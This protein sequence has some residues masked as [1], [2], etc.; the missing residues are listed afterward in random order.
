MFRPIKPR[1]WVQFP[2]VPGRRPLVIHWSIT[3]NCNTKILLRYIRNTDHRWWSKR[4]L[5]IIRVP[6]KKK[7]KRYLT[8]K[9][10]SLFSIILLDVIY[11]V[12]FN[13]HLKIMC[14]FMYEQCSN[15]QNSNKFLGE[16]L[17]EL[18][19]VLPILLCNKQKQF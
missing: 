16:N 15:L 13:S 3:Y 7:F 10:L 2:C 19:S 6:H 18:S 8:I 9:I 12:I 4:W 5:P 11:Q 1:L 14:V 17:L